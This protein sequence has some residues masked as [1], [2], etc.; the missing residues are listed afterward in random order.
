MADRQRKTL[1]GRLFA[2]FFS[3]SL[4]ILLIGVA[5]AVAVSWVVYEGTAEQRLSAEAQAVAEN[6][7]GMPEDAAIELLENSALPD[8]RITMVTGDGKVVYDSQVDAA[9]LP[10]HATR[11]EIVA[12]REKGV[13]AVLR[14]SDTTGS[15]TLYVAA[16]VPQGSYVIRLAETRASL[17]FYLSRMAVSL[18]FILALALLLSYVLARA[19]ARKIAA[20]LVDVD[21][22]DPLAC[23]AYVEVMPLLERV[24]AQKAELL[25]N[26]QKLQGAVEARREFTGNVSHEMKS[27]LQVIGGYAELIETGVANGEDARRFAGLISSEAKS[28]RTLIDDVLVLSKLDEMQVDQSSS[29]DL[30]AASG[31]AI[32][33]LESA[34]KERGVSV[35]LG[36]G[37]CACVRGP[38]SLAEQM[39]YNLVDNAIRYGRQGGVVEVAITTGSGSAQLA[40]SD[41]GAGVP[42][43]LRDRIFERFYRADESRSRETG[44]TGLGLAIVKHAALS[45]GGS[46][47][48]EEAS[49]GGLAVIVELP[50]AE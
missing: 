31:S 35:T 22:D 6:L 3:L 50:L 2:A 25:E 23:D 34:A 29:F 38:V 45:M 30:A 9:G 12:A 26:N 46:V 41:D 11:G 8:T 1:S 13:S 17:S 39:V 18:A 36:A 28:M 49:A 33:R 32:A 37:Q 14:H 27:P 48:A 10:S 24:D 16:A 47:R 21:L 19:V 43:E 40:V 15:D 5:A 42:P 4:G 7:S 44:G 20:P